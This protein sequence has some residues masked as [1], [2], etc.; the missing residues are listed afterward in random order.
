M[1]DY[2][3][4]RA[5]EALKTSTRAVLATSG[6]AGLQISEVACQAVGV[7]LYL[8]VPRTSDHLFNLEQDPHVTLLSAGWEV[9]G[10]AKVCREEEA[11]LDLLRD[12]E[13][14]WCVLVWVQACQV[15]I[16]TEGDWGNRETIDLG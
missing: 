11:V 10:K 16:R 3:R 7:A 14:E 5:G 15:H 8:W 13:A 1:L 4:Q 12:R 2:A 9:R 6:P